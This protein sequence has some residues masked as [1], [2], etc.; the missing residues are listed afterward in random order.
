MDKPLAKQQETRGY[1]QRWIALAFL[2]FSLLIISIDNTVLNVALPTI[3]EDLGASASGLQWI[4]DAYV[5]VFA[6]LLLTT[7]A[8]GDRFGRKRALQIGLGIFGIGSLAAALST[9]TG[10]LIGCRAFC[11]FGGATIMPATLSII[12]ATFRDPQERAKAIAIWAGVFGLGMGVGPVIAGSLLEHFSWS[13]VFYINLPVVAIGLIGGYFFIEDSRDERA[14]R[15]DIPGVL[16]SITGLFAL[17]YGIIKAG[18]ESWTA[19]SVIW[20]LCIAAIL[21]VAFVWWE[22]R[23]SNPMIP[24]DLF[25][26]MSFTGANIALTLVMFSMFGSMFF[27]SQ[28]FQ[29]VQGCSPLSAGLR[30]LPMA[31]IQM[32]VAVNS[33]RVAQ[34]V[35]TKLTVGLGIMGAAIGLFYLSRVA[36]VDTPYWVILIGMSIMAAGMA[37]AMSPATNS[38]MGSV[39]VRKSGVGSAMNNTM[40]QVGGALG[41]A[42]LGTVMNATYLHKVK[43]LEGNTSIPDA[44]Q[45]AIRSSIQAAHM[46]AGRIQELSPDLAQTVTNV[47]N[48]GFVSGM[49]D[50]FLIAS[51][52]MAIAALVTLIILPTWVQPPEEE[53]H[54]ERV[55]GNQPS[56]VPPQVE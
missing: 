19:D 17:V 37:T 39:P 1:R 2:S 3:A 36:H 40:R 38:I 4:V 27:M 6:A 30:V 16:L 8:F 24:M 31:P 15:T 12:S 42:I 53:Q 7:G 52:I 44:A 10:M 43:A 56:D 47:S 23:T 48:D 35:G 34:K 29:S 13:S 28:F 21:I 14:P 41:V 5:L 54:H 49:R 26:N 9:S 20:S 51:I 55:D 25:R 22:R 46:A 18:E 11:G 33:A 32:I 45:E 50:A